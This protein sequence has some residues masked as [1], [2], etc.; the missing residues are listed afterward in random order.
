MKERISVEEASVVLGIPPTRIRNRLRRDYIKKTNDFPVGH[1]H[2]AET[3]KSFR[4]ELYRS[5][6]MKYL[7][8][9][10]WPGEGEQDE[11]G[12]KNNL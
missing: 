12:Q 7:G 9:D 4:Y 8:L 5:M 11:Q 10:K 2:R 6:I 1:A 3:G